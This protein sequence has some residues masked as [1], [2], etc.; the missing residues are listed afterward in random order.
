MSITTRDLASPSPLSHAI[1]NARPYA[2]LDDGAAEERR[3]KAVS[4]QPIMDLQTAQDIG[5]LDPQVIAQVREDAWPEIGN[6]EELHDALV[7]HGFLTVDEA[8]FPEFAA[9]ARA[10]APHHPPG[11]SSAGTLYVAAE[12]LH[13]LQA[14]FPDAALS[15]AIEP[16]Y[17]PEAHARRS[18]ARDP[19]RTA[20][21]CSA[22]SPP[23]RWAR[24]WA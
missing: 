23:R 11:R 19:A 6:A 18:L 22:P 10:A 17:A 15:P 5:K 4:M 14:V 20:G 7:V 13:E 3:T 12:R 2:F 8:P 16:V 21:A 9:G 1:L 24:R